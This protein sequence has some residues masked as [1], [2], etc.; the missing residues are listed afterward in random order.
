MFNAGFV[1]VD[2]GSSEVVALLDMFE[3]FEVFEMFKVFEVFVIDV[4]ESRLDVDGIAVESEAIG[5]VASIIFLLNMPGVGAL[6]L[7]EPRFNASSVII[8]K[9]PTN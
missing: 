6:V 3:I 5:E 7:T 8:K 9:N 1:T 4:T 2:E